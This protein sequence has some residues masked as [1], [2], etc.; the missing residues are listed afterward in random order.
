MK[1]TFGCGC[2]DRGDPDL[3][4]MCVAAVALTFTIEGPL[5]HGRATGD[6]G[7]FQQMAADLRKHVHHP[8]SVAA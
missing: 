1:V 6:Y 3:S 4:T 8:K 2:V 5:R 7:P